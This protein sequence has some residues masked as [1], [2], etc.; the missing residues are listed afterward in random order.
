[1]TEEELC[2]LEDK[3]CPGCG[4]CAGMFTANSM[5]SLAEVLGLATEDSTWFA[6]QVYSLSGAG[7]DI[8]RITCN[9]VE[10]AQGNLEQNIAI[11]T[12]DEVE[13]L[14]ANFSFMIREIR[15]QKRQLEEHLEE[16]RQLQQYA[17]EILSTM[18][19]GLFAVDMDARVTAVNPAAHSRLSMI[20]H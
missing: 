8:V 3:A 16:I 20:D 18:N 9:T 17:E 12:R 5:N 6:A 15:G 1:M 14:A 7:A 19:D 10:A 11:H 4:S 13:I 2:E